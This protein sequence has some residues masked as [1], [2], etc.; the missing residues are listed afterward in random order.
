MVWNKKSQ[1]L[2][3]MDAMSSRS[4]NKVMV[5][6][7]GGTQSMHLKL[8]VLTQTPEFWRVLES[9]VSGVS[10]SYVLACTCRAVAPISDVCSVTPEYWLVM[11]QAI[12]RAVEV[13][14]Y[15][16]V[17]VLHDA[18]ILTYS[19]AVMS[20]FLLGLPAAVVFTGAMIAVDAADSDV[21]ENIAGGIMSLAKGLPNGVHLF[22][23]GE[24]LNPLC[25]TKIKTKGRHPYVEHACFTCQL[26]ASCW[27]AQINFKT[28]MKPV[29]VVVLPVF[30]GVNAEFIDG[31]VGSGIHALVLEHHSDGFV[32]DEVLGH[33][34]VRSLR[35][36]YDKGIVIVVISTCFGQKI[37]TVSTN[38][39]AAGVISS[40][41]IT[42]EVIL[43]KLHALL[44][45]GLNQEQIIAY[46]GGDKF[47]R[48]HWA[49]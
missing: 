3:V 37:H 12:V 10:T 47:R 24:I 15:S 16:C 43:G 21:W 39:R 2:S 1:G 48:Y 42:R 23:H 38:A 20:F 26:D 7:A 4:L 32:I 34:L 46:I 22:F 35:A 9:S 8:S 19:A 11:R 14:G 18:D 25:A 5:L 27:P 13:E 44:G 31:L 36:A 49:Q 29:N 28:P 6:Y 40:G 41:Y 45:A 30:P 33:G 17:L